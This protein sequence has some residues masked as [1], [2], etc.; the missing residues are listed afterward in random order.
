MDDCFTRHGELIAKAPAYRQHFADY[1]KTN[2]LEQL[3]RGV[4]KKYATDPDYATKLLK[5]LGMPDVK[6]ALG[7]LKAA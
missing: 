1:G 6:A 3:I 7:Q 2:D 4:A 5:I